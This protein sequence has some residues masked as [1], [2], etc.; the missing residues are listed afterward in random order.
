DDDPT[1]KVPEDEAKYD[2]KS[3]ITAILERINQLGE[4]LNKKIDNAVSE[5]SNRLTVEIESLRAEM[6]TG[7]EKIDRRLDVLSGEIID[8]KDNHRKLKARVDKLE[9]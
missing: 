5:L 4:Q 1:R 7:F 8:I 3:G 6:Q 9:E 2:T